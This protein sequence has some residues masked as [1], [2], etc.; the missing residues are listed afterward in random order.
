MDKYDLVLDIIGHPENFSQ[1]QLKE[2]LADKETRE[3]YNLLCKTGS[4]VNH[5]CDSPDVDAEWEAFKTKRL[6]GDGGNSAKPARRIKL[7]SWLSSRAASTAIV[8]GLSITSIAAIG[9]GI[10]M[11]SDRQQTAAK[12]T[13]ADVKPLAPAAAEGD[14]IQNA[15]RQKPAPAE[16]IVF[17][18][19]TL[20][21]I[22]TA[23]GEYYGV[24]VRYANNEAKALRLYFRL[25]ASLPLAEVIGQLNTFDRID[26]TLK[27]NT[28]TVN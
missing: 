10:K 14:T 19:A 25:D 28:L 12:E 13:V 17:E 20:E 24:S 27:D 2:L 18:N 5:E 23:I 1:E 26:I 16:P 22:M 8:V 3:I 6:T 7:T 11:M 15:A 4:A 9:I 21:T